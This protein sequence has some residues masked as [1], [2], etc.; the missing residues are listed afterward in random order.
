MP[1]RDR[2]R[3]GEVRTVYQRHPYPPV[4]PGSVPSA[5]WRLPPPEWLQALWRPASR[6]FA[7]ARVLIAGCGTGGE[8]FALAKRAPGA[9][10]VALDFSPRAIRLARAQQK[11][12]ADGARITFR[13]ADLSDPRLPELTGGHFDFI[14]CHGVLSY[15]PDPRGV[16]KNLTRC[17][18]DDGALYIGVNGATHHSVRWRRAVTAFGLDPAAWPD[19]E[20]S[21][22]VLRLLDALAETSASPRLAHRSAAY[23]ASDVF[24][25]EI[26]NLPLEQWLAMTRAAGLHFCGS[27]SCVESLKGLCERRLTDDL[28]PRSRAELHALE[29]ELMPSAFHRLLFTRR[30]PERCPWERPATLAHW[31]PVTLGLYRAKVSPRRTGPFRHVELVSRALNLRVELWLETWACELIAAATGDRSV[32]ALTRDARPRPNLTSARQTLY[33][34][35]LLGVIELLPPVTPQSAT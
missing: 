17:L 32:R 20:P 1:S 28:L 35:Y 22:R 14:S 19:D 30:A 8:A 24:G 25:P 26:R 2:G 4:T 3:G 33:L 27:H 21:R 34:L 10:I 7:P 23:L 13:Q 18:A 11:R 31:R 9:V 15:V 29:E 16:L 12:V 6:R 5:D